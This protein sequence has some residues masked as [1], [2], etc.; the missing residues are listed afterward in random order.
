MR[1]A[2][3]PLTLALSLVACGGSGSVPSAQP[4]FAKTIRPDYEVCGSRGFHR[5]D[6]NGGVQDVPHIAKEKQFMGD[7]GYAPISGGGKVKGLVFS[8]STSDPL[9][10]IP[11]GYSPDWFGSWTLYC[12]DHNECA[13]VSFGNGRLSGN[14]TSDVWL[15]S[16]TY[17]LYVYAS[18]SRQYIESYQIGPV[19]PRKHGNSSISFDSPF[20]NGLTYPED[21]G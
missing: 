12:S 6:A 8:C 13:S 16:R 9:A 4:A 2:L 15:S 1:T 20:E 18:D 10:P 19:T 17:Y 5:L 14:I 21:E 7:F 3:V 11:Q